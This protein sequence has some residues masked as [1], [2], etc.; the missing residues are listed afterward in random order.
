MKIIQ[1]EMS[2]VVS[3]VCFILLLS[4]YVLR[5]HYI[6]LSL[7]TEQLSLIWR[8]CLC[9]RTLEQ[10]CGLFVWLLKLFLS[11]VGIRK[12]FSTVCMNCR[13]KLGVHQENT[14]TCEKVF[15]YDKNV[16]YKFFLHLIIVISIVS[17]NV[18]KTFIYHKN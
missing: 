4:K 2:C 7:F 13:P 3:L 1:L 6:S 12:I 5:T 18:T 11:T 15:V 16:K 17:K 10:C 14:H 9:L 8:F